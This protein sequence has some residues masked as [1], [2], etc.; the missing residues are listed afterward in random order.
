M[1][2]PTGIWQLDT[3]ASTVTVSVK[4]MGLF[5]VPATLAVTSGTIEIDDNNQV[6]NVEVIA[7]ASSY[8]SKSGKRNEHVLGSDFLDAE[9]HPTIGFR[10]SRVA[11]E[12]PGYTSSGTITVKGQ[13]SPID[14]TIT[15]VD[16]SDTVGSFTA[17]AS[18][19]R[20]TVGIDKMPTLIIGRNLQLA[21][22]AKARKNS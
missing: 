16:V 10:T 14:V 18:V 13:P 1:K 6:T 20:K 22:S 9:N 15:D 7:D 5:T 3:S 19:D 12:S 17:T 21:V 11:S 2:L 4:K 8:N